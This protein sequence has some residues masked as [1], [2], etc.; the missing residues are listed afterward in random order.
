MTQCNTLNVT[1][2][3]SQL[4][5]LKS[6][7]KNGTEVTLNLLSNLI[8]NSNYETNFLHKLLLTDTQVSRIRKAFAKAFS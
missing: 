5:K 1:L 2:C 6:E 3:N 4:N 8:G 7:I